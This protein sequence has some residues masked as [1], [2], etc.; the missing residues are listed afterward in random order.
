[1]GPRR[2]AGRLVRLG[3]ATALALSIVAGSASPARAGLVGDLTGTLTGIVDGLGGA[4]LGNGFHLG[5][6]DEFEPDGT[7]VRLGQVR[8]AI[9][10]D[11]AVA[12]GIDGSGIDV[13]LIDTGSVPV[14]GLD[15]SATVTVG[16]DL[17]FDRQGGVGAGLDGYGH[18][19]HMAGI[20]AARGDASNRGLAPAARLVNLKVGA[21]SGAVDVSQVI[22]AVD[23][24]VQNRNA[25][26]LNIRVINLSYGTDG[27]QSYQLDPLAHAVES[28]WRNGIVVVVAAGNSGAALTNPA[29]DPYVL[30]VGA[31]DLK[32]PA[33]TGDDAVAE[34]SSIGDDTRRVDVVAPGSSV[35]SLRDPGST[36][37]RAHPD[38]RVDSRYFRGSGTSQAAAVTSGVVAS[39]LEARPSLTPDGVKSVLR[40]S[41]RVLSTSSAAAQGAGMIDLAAALRATPRTT[42][43]LPAS[44]GLGTLEAARGTVHVVLDGEALTGEID[45]QSGAWRPSVWAP[46]SAAGTAWSGGTWNANVWTGTTWA[47]GDPSW[48]GRTWKSAAWTGRTWKGDAWTGRTWKSDTWTGRTW[49][50]T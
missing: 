40:S 19:T 49:K 43:A 27:V 47:S 34:F 9:N 50:S 7:P 6:F 39:L 45:A 21:G 20:I 25:D 4:V 28:A 33:R 8:R 35:I 11:A 36:I 29:V 13:A 23:W 17:S 37:D 2:S 18:G 46:L 48:T 31:V 3:T 1:M 10:G 32:D 38:A 12:S 30:T 41:A 5:L 15:G 44:T 24:A 16:P 26:G 22:A 14:A 42:Q